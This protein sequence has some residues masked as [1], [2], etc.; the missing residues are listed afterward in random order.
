[1][2]TDA[3]YCYLGIDR[4]EDARLLAEEQ[5]KSDLLSDLQKADY[6]C[7]LGDINNDEES[8]ERAWRI[9]KGR[10][11]RSMRSLGTLLVHQKRHKDAANAFE[12]ALN[13]NHLHPGTWFVYGICNFV[14]EEFKL[15][16]K[17]FRQCVR[18]EY[19]NFEAWANLSNAELKAGNKVAAHRTLNEAIKCNYEKWELWENFI[20]IATDIGDFNGSIRNVSNKKLLADRTVRERSCTIGIR[21]VLLVVSYVFQ[22]TLDETITEPMFVYWK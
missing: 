15:A 18:L 21:P 8:Y 4:L 7:V 20:T 1:M 17:G 22:E 5:L 3:C 12:R 10:H 16:A 19:D 2:F 6:F 11:A 9:S 13:L 14:C